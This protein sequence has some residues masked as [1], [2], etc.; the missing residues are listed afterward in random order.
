MAPFTEVV[1]N[2]NTMTQELQ[3]VE[4]LRADFINDF[5]HEFKTPITSINGFATLLLDTEVDDKTRNE[6]LKIIA[7]ESERLSHLA[8]QTILMSRLDSQTSIPDKVLFSLDEQIKQDIILLSNNWTSKNID[9]DIDLAS[10]KYYGNPSMMAHIWINLLTNAIKFT[11][12]HGTIRI[13]CYKEQDNI[14]CSISDTG[15]GMTREEQQRIF[16]RYY[17]SDKS[18]ATQGLGLGLSIVHRIIELC[19]GSISVTSTTGSGSTFTVTLPI[20]NVEN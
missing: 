14:I 15:K 20:K 9:M 12:E 17:Q 18:H 5:S 19:N 2:L 11:P 13:R 6:Y 8:E 7:D 3:S 1:T 16:N 10:V 4:T